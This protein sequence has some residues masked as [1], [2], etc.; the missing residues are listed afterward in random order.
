MGETD[1][2]IGTS[3]SDPGEGKLTICRT[4]GC[5]IVFDPKW[6]VRLAN[7]PVEMSNLCPRCGAD[8][9]RNSFIRRANDEVCVPQKEQ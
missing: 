4:P 3:P 1:V 5:L 7:E 8:L 9:S 2:I 6:R